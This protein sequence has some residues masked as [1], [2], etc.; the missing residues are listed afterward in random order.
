MTAMKAADDPPVAIRD[1]GP[2]VR[3]AVHIRDVRL[4]ERDGWT[5]LS[6]SVDGD[7]LRFRFPRA[8]QLEARAEA[9]VGPALFEAMVRNVP[10]VIDDPAPLSRALHTRLNDIQRVFA[11]WNGEL[12]VVPIEAR[13]LDE[14]PGTDEVLACFSGGID[15]TYTYGTH[16]DRVTQ[17]LLIEGF[18][19]GRGGERDWEGNVAA[20]ARF[21]GEE[22]RQLI[23]VGSNV[24]GWLAK[25][26]LSLLLTHGAILCSIAATLRPSCFLVPASHTADELAPWGSHPLVDPLWSTP[27]TEV[28]HHGFTVAR[29]EKTRAL[30]PDQRLLDQLQVC[31][32]AGSRNCGECGKCMRTA[33]TLQLLGARSASLKP[34]TH[35]AQ[36][37]LLKPTDQSHVH[38]LNEII[39]L[40][41]EV[42]RHDIA[43][44]LRGYVRRFQILRASGDLVRELAGA[45]AIR[46]WHRARPHAWHKARGLLRPRADA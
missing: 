29:T 10:L 24:R 42:G 16:R 4:V 11:T 15:S 12:A 44:I 1:A 31:W 21:A 9:F 13:R 39:W 18:A 40:A 20:R 45:R 30:C 33:L 17:L 7:M 14:P 22:G 43:D 38:F 27:A 36:L 6:A 19:A 46:L 41:T 25:R 37:A 3:D 23:A 2:G 34:Y 5:E 35:R 26:E 8:V 32:F 28:I